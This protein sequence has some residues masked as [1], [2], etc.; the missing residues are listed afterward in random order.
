[1]EH[2]KTLSSSCMLLNVTL[3]GSAGRSSLTSMALMPIVI[4]Y[5]QK[6]CTSMPTSSDSLSNIVC[7]LQKK[8][9]VK[10]TVTDTAKKKGEITNRGKSGKASTSTTVEWYSEKSTPHMCQQCDDTRV[11]ITWHD[12]HKTLLQNITGHLAQPK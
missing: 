2:S 5:G 11:K 8:S 9:K 3:G 4:L 7:C 1:M 6:H 10:T 12:Q